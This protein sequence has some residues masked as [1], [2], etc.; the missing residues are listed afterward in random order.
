MRSTATGGAGGPGLAVL[1]GGP[2][3]SDLRLTTVAGPGQAWVSNGP[4]PAGTRGVATVGDEVDAFVPSGVKLRIW[5]A[6][7][8]G[9]WHVTADLT[10]PIQYGSS[11]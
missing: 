11:D 3:A 10:V 5:A 4:P 6:T 7:G 1:L 2:S 9:P 8:A